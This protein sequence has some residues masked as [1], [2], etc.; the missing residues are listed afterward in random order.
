ML[1]FT[2]YLVLHTM[3]TSSVLEKKGIGRKIFEIQCQI[4]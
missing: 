3:F 1:Y 2:I 4:T